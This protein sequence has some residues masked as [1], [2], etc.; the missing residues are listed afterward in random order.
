[1]AQT[2]LIKA[3]KKNSKGVAFRVIKDRAWDDM[4]W[5]F[6]VQKQV[7]NYKHGK[8]HI[9]WVYTDKVKT[10]DEAIRIFEKKTAR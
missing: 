6:L 2:I 9:S 8:D 7:T 10:E 4:P 1:M 3:A 5:S